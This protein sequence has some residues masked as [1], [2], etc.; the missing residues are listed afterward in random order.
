LVDADIAG[1][2]RTAALA[3]LDLAE[4]RVLHG[5]PADAL[6]CARRAVDEARAIR[7]VAL[8]AKASRALGQVLLDLGVPAEA[9]PIL[10]DA[11]ALARAAGVA[12]ERLA[13]HV[14]RAR[15]TLDARP[16]DLT[17]ASVALDRLAPWG[18]EAGPD[19]ESVYPLLHGVRARAHAVLGQTDRATEEG[20]RAQAGGARAPRAMRLRAGNEVV[21]AWVTSG[22]VDTARALA[23]SMA[24]EAQAGGMRLL[25]WEAGSLAARLAFGELPALE[26]FL[27]GL[28]AEHA[29]ALRR[30]FGG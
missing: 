21:R 2:R 25:A 29:A 5:E 18:S 12:E 14:L 30:R 11:S 23:A 13:A 4:A 22:E 28:S 17:A 9:E 8:Q 7:D 1:D 6:R 3:C 26:P 19:P 20:R 16:G 27:P 24:A 15:A 10:G